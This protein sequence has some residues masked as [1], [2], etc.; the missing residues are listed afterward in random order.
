MKLRNVATGTLALTLLFFAGCGEGGPKGE[1][2]SVA[3]QFL[4]RYYVQGNVEE[5]KALATGDMAKKMGE[6]FALL[7]KAV[8][9]DQGKSY[10]VSYT[11]SEQF[12]EGNHAYQL[13]LVVLK[14]KEGDPIYKKV[15]LSID[16]VEK[17]WLITQFDEAPGEPSQTI[18]R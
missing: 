5:A 9:R 4:D 3:K 17:D 1:P 11:L 15:A 2:A 8:P 12:R 18:K 6:E 7:A 14:P 16:A 13:Y 10:E